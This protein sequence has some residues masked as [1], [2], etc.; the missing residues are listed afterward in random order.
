MVILAPAMLLMVMAIVQFGLWFHAMHVA[1]A[2]ADEASRAAR[3]QGGTEAA[4]K[5][6]GVAF[7]AG[8]RDLIPD[9]DVDVRFVGAENVLVEV[10]GHVVS[11]LFGYDFEVR[12]VV[13]SPRERFIAAP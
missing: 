12:A 13:E 7:L 10:T 3:A 4:G 11:V 8:D 1:Q 2:A 5:A 6:K 9:A